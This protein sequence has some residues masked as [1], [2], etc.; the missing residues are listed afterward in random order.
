MTLF[1]F[2]ENL[3]TYLREEFVEILV[4]NGLLQFDRHIIFL[5]KHFEFVENI[6]PGSTIA[7]VG[8]SL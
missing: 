6:F 8:N 4:F 1:M 7:F 3:D 2:A 5:F